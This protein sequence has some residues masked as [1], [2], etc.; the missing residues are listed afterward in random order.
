MAYFPSWRKARSERGDGTRVR[1]VPSRGA[2]RA[3]TAAL[4]CALLTAFALVP[5]APAA[6]LSPPVLA[7]FERTSPDTI[8]AGDTV[9]INFSTDIPVASGVLELSYGLYSRRG[10]SWGTEGGPELTQH[11]ISLPTDAGSWLGGPYLVEYLWF[12]PSETHFYGSIR[13][14]RPGGESLPAAD[15]TV[16]NTGLTADRPRL[17]GVEVTSA[18][19]LAPGEDA[20]VAFSLTAPA[21]S[22]KLRFSDE[23]L[24]KDKYFEWTG[25]PAPGPFTGEVRIP[26]E[27]GFFESKYE[28]RSVTVTYLWIQA[29]HIFTQPDWPEGAGTFSV[30]NPGNPLQTLENLSP[31]II[32]MGDYP[33]NVEDLLKYGRIRLSYTWGKWS[34]TPTES[35][36]RWRRN[37]EY[38]CGAMWCGSFYATSASD[39]GSVLDNE[40]TVLLEG[41]K[42]V[43]AL[44]NR[45]YFSR[46]GPTTVVGSRRVGSELR[47]GFDLSTVTALPEGAAPTV[48]F[49]WKDSADPTNVLDT[50][51]T[52]QLTEADLGRTVRAVAVVE[53]DGQT[54]ARVV[55]RDIGPVGKASRLS[56]FNKDRFNDL[57]AVDGAGV[58][59]MYT[60]GPSGWPPHVNV[61]WGWN[62]FNLVFSPGDFSG[63]GSVDVM[64][65]DSG[66]RLWLY[67]GNGSGGWL[68]AS[69]VGIGWSGMTEILGPGDFNGDG[70]SDVLARDASGRLL[71]YPGNGHGGWLAPR[72]V[73]TG[74]NIFNK[75]ITPGDFDGDGGSDVLARTGHGDLHLYRFSLDGLFLGSSI[76]GIGWDV[77]PTFGSIGDTTGDGWNDL[78]A[79]NREGFLLVY[80][81]MATGW[82]TPQRQGPDWEA[83][84]FIF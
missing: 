4:L 28:L 9:T 29:K 81:H 8:N 39:M 20:V 53:F 63:D 24:L 40:V 46:S 59:R 80:P 22:V 77:M 42:A 58:L 34:K 36:N 61:G 32:S 57:F 21:Q 19:V 16:N 13:R 2:A 45:I 25:S 14:G 23:S 44:S 3:T 84:Q 70:T 1:K 41:H 6:G 49:E 60:A 10:F 78:Y 66:G 18:D 37:G 82:A 72:Q 17:V 69:I 73:G 35:R 64:A 27:A 79:I 5:L 54:V 51:D 62:I 33:D 47:A 71:L 15:F 83:M 12:R 74:W 26:I 56:D 11:V 38:H 43:S 68:R 67:E 65:R 75:I 7:H 30:V 48:K 55:S 76:V 52:Y 31:P 50:A